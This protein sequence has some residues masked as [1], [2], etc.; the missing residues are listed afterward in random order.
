MTFNHFDSL[1]RTNDFWSFPI[2]Q[3]NQHL[4][5]NHHK[6]L[7][8][9][10]GVAVVAGCP[11]PEEILQNIQ[12]LQSG[13]DRTLKAN[14]STAKV[15]WRKEMKALHFLIY[16]LMI[17][18]HYHP[19]T[20]WPLHEEQ[21]KKLQDAISRFGGFSLELQG[22]GILGMGA[23]SLRISDSP[24][25]E[26]LRDAI[27]AI[28]NVSPE[29]FGSRTK[30]IIIGRVIPPITKEDREAIRRTCDIFQAF[31]I[32]TLKIDALEVVHYKN[33]F[34]DAEYERVRLVK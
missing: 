9:R 25:L 6:D 2:E 33:K 26:K 4:E 19:E 31:T 1:I 15:E 16:G 17:P 18:D 7:L 30:K 20:S 27:A 5:R 29:R 28:E 34:L 14:G 13:F 12:V 23:V 3:I 22:M 11:L 24:E 8:Q 21:L 10:P 32:G